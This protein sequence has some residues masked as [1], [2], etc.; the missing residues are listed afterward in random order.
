MLCHLV[1]WTKLGVFVVEVPF[2]ENFMNSVIAKL[3]VF[4]ISHI[5]PKMMLEIQLTA[6]LDTTTLTGKNSFIYN[7]YASLCYLLKSFFF[8]LI[9]C[10]ISK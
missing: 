5:L 8:K 6:G 9:R 3:E 7:I 4:W 2:N 10:S 1:V